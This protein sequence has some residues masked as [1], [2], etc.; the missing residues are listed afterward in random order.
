MHPI[1]DIRSQRQRGQA[2]RRGPGG[3]AAP[4]LRAASRTHLPSHYLPQQQ[5]HEPNLR[6]PDRKWQQMQAFMP[7]EFRIAP[8]SP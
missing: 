6:N 1:C 5:R 4:G 8:G 2:R 3:A 7:P